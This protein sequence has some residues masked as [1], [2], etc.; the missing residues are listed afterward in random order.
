ML[1]EG[2]ATARQ[3]RAINKTMKGRRRG[4]K[5]S[6]RAGLEQFQGRIRRARRAKPWYEHSSGYFSVLEMNNERR[7]GSEVSKQG[8]GSHGHWAG[9]ATTGQGNV[10]AG[11]LYTGKEW[12]KQDMKNR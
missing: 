12:P 8:Q 9:R 5:P 11:L 7:A 3:G 10:R 6:G 1:Y 2:E 4:F